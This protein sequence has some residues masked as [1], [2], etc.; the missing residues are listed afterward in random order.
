MQETNHASTGE[1][2]PLEIRLKR[3]WDNHWY[4]YKVHTWIV[5]VL[6][7][8]IALFVGEKLTQ[9]HPD[10]S[11][12]YIGSSYVDETFGEK[13]SR[14]F[15]DVIT[16]LNGD[17]EKIVQV[18][19]VLFNGSEDLMNLA[20]L[21]QADIDFMSGRS[22]LY[23]IDSFAYET[24]I[25]R[26]AFVQME[27]SQGE[28]SYIDLSDNRLLNSDGFHFDNVYLCQRQPSFEDKDDDETRL[29]YQ[30]A[31]AITEKILQYQ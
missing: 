5:I 30:N 8:C 12:T 16:D 10:V 29:K 26:G 2:E 24:F 21:Q 17:G 1:R 3:A 28:F 15:S 13:L 9:V 18:N 4:H 20:T 19:S 22:V 23:L 31:A 27:T 25:E 14:D 6:V 7:F 11:I